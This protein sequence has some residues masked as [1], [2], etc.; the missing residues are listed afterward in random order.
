MTQF[1]NS[2]ATKGS[3]RQF[4]L[5]LAWNWCEDLP[6]RI[7]SFRLTLIGRPRF[8]GWTFLGA[9]R[10][11]AAALH[12]PWGQGEPVSRRRVAC[13]LLSERSISPRS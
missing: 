13:Y 8:R 1:P 11:Y 12:Q 7:L 2:A 5:T 4:L 9:H 6:S 10:S 3:N